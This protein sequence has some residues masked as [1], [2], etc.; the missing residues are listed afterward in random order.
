MSLSRFS[1]IVSIDAGGGIAK[2][3]DIPWQCASYSKYFRE[4]T[5][6]RGRNAIIMGKT[7]YESIP[8]DKRPLEGRHTVV[9]SRTLKQELHPH[10]KVCDSLIDALAMLGAIA[11]NYDDVFIAGGEQIYQE[12]VNVLGYLCNKIHVTKFKTDYKCD[13]FFPWKEVC[14]LRDAKT[15]EPTRDFTRYVFAPEEVHSEDIYLNTL[16][17]V[18]EDGEVKVD[19][20]NQGVTSKFGVKLEFKDI[21][22]ALPLITT[23]RLDYDSIIKEL[24][25]FVSGKTDATILKNQGVTN[26][27]V[28][29]TTREELDAKGFDEREIGDLGPYAG[30]QLRHAGVVYEGADKVY[31]GLDQLKALIRNIR[32][33]PHSRSHMLSLWCAKDVPEMGAEPIACMVQ[34]NVSGDRKFLDCQVYVKSEDIFSHTPHTLTTYSLLTYMIAHITNLKPRKLCCVI[35]EAY[36]PVASSDQPKRQLQRTPR[37]FPTLSFRGGTK[38]HEIDDFVFQSFIVEGYIPCAAINAKN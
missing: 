22:K 27:L 3:G 24:L 5:L 12:A 20:L 32:T 13:Q 16:R 1:I 31:E 8:E 19:D 10:I 15:P 17:D 36:T 35:G 6:G 29:L 37:P 25:F 7:T 26:A 30:F 18:I 21:S 4:L 2:D 34:Y 9:I 23:R 28:S 14:K 11:K 38:L 33:N